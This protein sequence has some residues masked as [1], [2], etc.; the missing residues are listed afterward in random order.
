MLKNTDE[1]LHADD[2]DVALFRAVRLTDKFKSLMKRVDALSRVNPYIINFS[3]ICDTAVRHGYYPSEKAFYDRIYV[4]ANSLDHFE[5][6]RWAFDHAMQIS[7]QQPKSQ[8]IRA[9]IIQAILM[10]H[11]H[12]IAPGA[13]TLTRR[14]L[15]TIVFTPE[16][17]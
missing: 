14:K 10:E 16:R 2:K 13:I 1:N 8:K 15:Q 4:V 7:S 6:H 17:K 9:L 11:E 12:L 3:E 5:I